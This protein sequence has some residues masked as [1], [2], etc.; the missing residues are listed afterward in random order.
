MASGQGTAVHEYFTM[1]LG[2]TPS[3]PT[4]KQLAVSSPCGQDC[5]K[6]I[7]AAKLLIDACDPSQHIEILRVANHGVQILWR[8]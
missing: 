7:C 8:G 6:V 2:Q 5:V 3:D 1:T 4:L